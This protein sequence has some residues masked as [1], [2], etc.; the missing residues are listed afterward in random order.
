MGI[1]V[2][3]CLAGPG[4]V[5]VQ[6]GGPGTNSQRPTTAPSRG[7]SQ[8]G[9][10]GPNPPGTLAWQVQQDTERQQEEYQQRQ[11]TYAQ[12]EQQY[13][14]QLYDQQQEQYNQQQQEEYISAR[15]YGT[16]YMLDETGRWA[17]PEVCGSQTI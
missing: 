5:L 10:R 13:N 11:H 16:Q 7:R 15:E 1:T 14:Q 3:Y 12:Q 4:I 2:L 6:K 8:S 9:W 17:D